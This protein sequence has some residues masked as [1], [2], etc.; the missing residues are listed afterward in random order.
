M[1]ELWLASSETTADWARMSVFGRGLHQ[2]AVSVDGERT[3]GRAAATVGFVVISTGGHPL[4]LVSARAAAQASCGSVRAQYPGRKR[5]R[6]AFI[7]KRFPTSTRWLAV[8]TFGVEKEIPW[9][10][11]SGTQHS[12]RASSWRRVWP[13]VRVPAETDRPT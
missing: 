13:A 6:K 2:S 7:P 12:A 4:S 1:M 8:Q 11:P 9:A 10:F 3:R 5:H